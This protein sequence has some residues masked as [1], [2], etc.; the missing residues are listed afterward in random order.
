[1]T[2]STTRVIIGMSLCRRMMTILYHVS[3]LKLC[4]RLYVETRLE[5]RMAQENLYVT[6]TLG[7]VARPPLLLWFYVLDHE[8]M[9]YKHLKVSNQV[10]PNMKVYLQ[11]FKFPLSFTKRYPTTSGSIAF[12]D[13]RAKMMDSVQVWRHSPLTDLGFGLLISLPSFDFI[14]CEKATRKC[15]NSSASN[16]TRQSVRSKI[17]ERHQKFSMKAK[18][19]RLVGLRRLRGTRKE[20]RLSQNTLYVISLPNWLKLRTCLTRLEPTQARF[21]FS[22]D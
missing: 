1:M 14:A 8:M 17:E 18:A 22:L 6:S 7:S 21:S 5:N 20:R 16:M 19:F 13:F 2:M 11:E 10:K 9:T 15:Y 3:S 4:H 12:Q